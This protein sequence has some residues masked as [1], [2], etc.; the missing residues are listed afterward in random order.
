ML[1]KS[2]MSNKY[3]KLTANQQQ[4][5]DTLNNVDF[6][7][8]EGY[9]VDLSKSKLLI[10]CAA[11]VTQPTAGADDDGK[12]YVQELGMQVVDGANR[13]AP[14]T[15]AVLVKNC[16][17]KA[18]KAGLI[19]SLRRVDVLRSGLTVYTKDVDEKLSQYPNGLD[20]PVGP[21]S[22]KSS[23]FVNY[24]KVGTVLST[25]VASSDVGI[26]LHEVMDFCEAPVYSTDK[27]GQ[28]HMHFEMNFDKLKIVALNTKEA[29]DANPPPSDSS[30]FGSFSNFT[31]TAAA[32]PVTSAISDKATNDPNVDFPFYVGERVLMTGT[33]D[34]VA[35]TK[36]RR[37][38]SISY[39]S[40]TGLS[41]IN[42]DSIG[43]LDDTKIAVFTK[44]TP[45]PSVAAPTYTIDNVELE[46]K[47]TDEE[48]PAQISYTT[49][50]T[51]EDTFPAATSKS[52]MY[53]IEPQADNLLVCIA[54]GGIF[55]DNLCDSYRFRVDNKEMSTG[56]V[57]RKDPEHRDNL[58]KLFLNMDLE[59]KDVS[60]RGFNGLKDST[61][62]NHHST[63]LGLIG[64]PLPVTQNQK[65]V[66]LEIAA[67]GMTELM[68]YKRM[69]K[70]I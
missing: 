51:E 63:R 17:M 10:T 44:I 57:V 62:A 3:I 34:G 8:P 28:T 48:P 4:F 54:N 45:A 19:E 66:N 24:K 60:E 37:I 50:S 27:Y 36:S 61:S 2:I 32:T 67:T 43:N 70:S 49:Y 14:N 52:K 38:N 15:A 30:A 55:A 42:F 69:V 25:Q 5:S 41:T 11:S 31:S 9:N 59:L 39:D 16:H 20:G 35:F 22:F 1:L 18:A 46:L 13:P 64:T 7:I 21:N 40:T 12:A 65:N 47:L 6:T 23:P 68:L 56:S 53:Q 29:G 26:P 33:L 58:N